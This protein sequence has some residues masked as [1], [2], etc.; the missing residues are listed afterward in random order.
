M[1]KDKK[2][3]GKLFDSIAGTY[4]RFNHLLSFNIDKKWRRRSVKRLLNAGNVL[5]VATGTAD[6]AMEIV[7][8]GKAASV[9]G[10]DIS[11][12]MMDIG[13]AKVEKAGMQDR[14]SFLEG[15][16]L[17]MPFPEGEFDAVVCAYGVRNFSDLDQGLS[18]MHRV[19]SGG[20]QLMIL[21]FSYPSNAFVRSLYDFFF[22]NVMPLVGKA[23]SKNG[24]AYK[25]FRDSVKGFIWGQEMADRIS[26]AGFKKVSFKTMTFG[27]T[28]VYFAEK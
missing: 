5:D 25:Y 15:S 28:T 23:L 24:G 7:R 13:R 18:E 10:M 20:G 27:I 26:A 11:T 16:A 6:L 12:G 8:Q 3:I 21:E 19:L 1:D 4:D 14:I 22:S 2:N 17:E 9:L